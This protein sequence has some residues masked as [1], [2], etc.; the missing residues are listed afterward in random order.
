MVIKIIATVVAMLCIVIFGCF[1]ICDKEGYFNAKK[2]VVSYANIF[3]DSKRKVRIIYAVLLILSVSIGIVETI[4]NDLIES[5]TLIVSVLSGAFLAFLPVV[6]DLKNK[7]IESN[8]E[9]IYENTCK[10]TISVLIFELLISIIELFFCF[11]YMFLYP[12][13]NLD[14]KTYMVV[15]IVFSSVIYYLMFIILLNILFILKRIRILISFQDN[16]KHT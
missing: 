14:D 15:L 10:E 4:N 1:L 13:I 8:R 12:K 6:M 3:S 7:D 11:V 9:V 5:V 16:H 2:I